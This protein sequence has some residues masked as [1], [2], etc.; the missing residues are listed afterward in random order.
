MRTCLIHMFRFVLTLCVLF[1]AA[2]SKEQL[3]EE[4]K[5]AGS[6]GKF[7]LSSMDFIADWTEPGTKSLYDLQDA[8]QKQIYNVYYFFYDEEGYLE[9]I[10][11]QDVEPTMR[12]EV[13]REHFKDADGN[14]APAHGVLFVIA[15]SEKMNVAGSNDGLPKLVSSKDV[16]VGDIN[17]WKQSVATVSD[18]KKK[19]LF[20]LFIEHAVDGVQGGS[21]KSGRPDHV[22]MLGYF[23]GALSHGTMQIPLGRLCARLRIALSGPGLGEQARITIENAALY[24]AVY[25]EFEGGRMPCASYNPEALDLSRFWGTFVETIDNHPKGADDNVNE[26]GVDKPGKD[27]YY[28]GIVTDSGG[29]RTANLFYFCGENDVDYTGTPTTLKIEIWDK[30][31]KPDANGDRTGDPTRTYRVELGQQSPYIE[32]RSLSLYRNTSYTFNLEL[33][34]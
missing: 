5:D 18:F 12:L 16:T 25:P 3:P 30:K 23:D 29:N 17:A 10:Y 4:M 1:M 6:G 28:G 9:R 14:E 27:G 22:I 13:L 32:N 11:Y 20:P 8:L 7:V 31:V 24:S 2:C 15:N 21:R 26:D 33:N 34:K 19:A